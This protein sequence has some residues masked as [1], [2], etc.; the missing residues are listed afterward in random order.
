MCFCGICM[1]AVLNWRHHHS[2]NQQLCNPHTTHNSRSVW[3]LD[4][5]WSDKDV[6]TF[7][8]QSYLQTEVSFDQMP[9]IILFCP[10]TTTWATCFFHQ[11]GNE[12]Q[13]LSQ[14]VF[15]SGLGIFW[16]F[17]INTAK[18]CCLNCFGIIVQLNSFCFSPTYQELF[19]FCV[20]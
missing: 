17:M 2:A 7:V 6:S 8:H 9:C 1:R 15:I 14:R 18:K 4:K 13:I 12:I 20:L 3:V 10:E 19:F 11:H 16:C 5:V